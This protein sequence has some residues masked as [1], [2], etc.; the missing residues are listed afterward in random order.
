MPGRSWFR[1][2]ANRDRDWIAGGEGRRERRVE[3]LLQRGLHG[4]R[5]NESFNLFVRH[6]LSASSIR[7]ATRRGREAVHAAVENGDA[8]VDGYTDG[9]FQDLPERDRAI[10]TESVKAALAVVGPANF[11]AWDVPA[12]EAAAFAE[13]REARAG[14]APGSGW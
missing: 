7:R 12:D 8:D 9:Q 13:A 1:R 3:T 6:H 4:R 14:S 11:D 10:I 2:R 5:T